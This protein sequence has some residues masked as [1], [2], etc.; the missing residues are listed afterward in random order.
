MQN[1]IFQPYNKM[2]M[3]FTDFQKKWKYLFPLSKKKIVNRSVFRKVIIYININS[4]Y[5]LSKC[6]QIREVIKMSR[7]RE[8]NLKTALHIFKTCKR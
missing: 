7:F 4:I 3:A 6:S 1:P 5:Y 2:F 8:I